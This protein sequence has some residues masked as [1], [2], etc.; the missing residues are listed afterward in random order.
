M[1]QRAE[2]TGS[3]VERDLSDPRIKANNS[4]NPSLDIDSSGNIIAVWKNADVKQVVA[5]YIPAEG[6]NS[7]FKLYSF[8]I[9]V[10]MHI[11]P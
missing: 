10:V 7:K 6:G 3:W 1:S 8:P 4:T 9:Q 5:S 2:E 11:Y